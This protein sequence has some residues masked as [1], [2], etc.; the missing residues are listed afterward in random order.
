MINSRRASTGLIVLIVLIAAILAMVQV[1]FPREGEPQAPRTLDV[2]APRVI[3]IRAQAPAFPFETI[4][5][6]ME[7]AEG[8]MLDGLCGEIQVW[9]FDPNDD[10][11]MWMTRDRFVAAHYSPPVGTPDWVY[12]GQLIDRSRLKVE[13]VDP[14]TPGGHPCD[15]LAPLAHH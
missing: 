10:W 5:Q 13:R 15:D 2:Q 8:R 4:Q 12:V 3:L 11:R 6:A 14:F 1:A 7:Q 9:S